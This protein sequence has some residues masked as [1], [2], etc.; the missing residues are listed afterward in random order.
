MKLPEYFNWRVRGCG[1]WPEFKTDKI[2]R[3]YRHGGIVPSGPM[4]LID[5][6]IAGKLHPDKIQYLHPSLKPILSPTYGVAVYQEQCM[7]IANKVAGYSMAEADNLR[8][9]IGKKKHSIMEI[10]KRNLSPDP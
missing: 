8:R 3:Y 7:Q 2:Q 1:D 6:F 10:E 9:A 4:E 5:D